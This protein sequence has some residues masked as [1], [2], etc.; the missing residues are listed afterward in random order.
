MDRVDDQ[1]FT[2]WESSST[3]GSSASRMSLITVY[4]GGRAGA[5]YSP[6]QP[7]G[8]PTKGVIATTLWAIDAVVPGVGTAFNGNAWLDSW[9]DDPW[10]G[11]SYAAF[12]PG[13]YSRFSGVSGTQEGTIHF[14]G[15]HTSSFSQGF[16]NGGVES[17][18]RAAIE[19]LKAIGTPV[20]P[21]LRRTMTAALG[22]RPR[23]PW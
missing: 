10:V 14:A 20:P 21:R 9:V 5:A 7:H 18:E 11:G 3:D 8:P 16:L 17:G 6:P 13:Q 2:T 22:Y 12:L 4:S 1:M 23:Y 15:E 19:V